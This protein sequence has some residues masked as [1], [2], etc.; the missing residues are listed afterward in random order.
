MSVFGRKHQHQ[1]KV[2]GVRF[3][4]RPEDLSRARWDP[5]PDLELIREVLYGFTLLTQQ[6]TECGW[7]ATSRTAGQPDLKTLDINSG[8]NVAPKGTA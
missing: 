7:V 3:H 8:V 6:C 2:I 5:D 4:P 1:W